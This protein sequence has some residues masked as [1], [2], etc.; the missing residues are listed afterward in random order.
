MSCL[1]KEVRVGAMSEVVREMGGGCTMLGRSLRRNIRACPAGGARAAP[2]L[3]GSITHADCRRPPMSASALETL[4][5][6]V[7]G[8]QLKT[9]PADRENNRSAERRGRKE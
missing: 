9:A 1:G 5:Q 3:P 4:G 8:L 6:A 7:P 2:P